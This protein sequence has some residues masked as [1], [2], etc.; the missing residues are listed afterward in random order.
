MAMLW[1]GLGLK[2]IVFVITHSVLWPVAVNTY[3]GFQSVSDTQKMAGRNIGLRGVRYVTQLLIPAALPSILAG[4]RLGWA[5]GWRSERSSKTHKRLRPTVSH[6][7][8][9]TTR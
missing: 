5:F 7:P 4:L 8:S 9:R 6:R 3:S 1:F 2:S